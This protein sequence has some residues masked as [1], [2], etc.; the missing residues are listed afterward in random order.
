ML[1][2]VTEH[3]PDTFSLFH[4]SRSK[5]KRKFDNDQPGNVGI[6]GVLSRLTRPKAP[7]GSL[8]RPEEVLFF[9]T[10][11]PELTVRECFDVSYVCRISETLPPLCQIDANA[12][13]LVA[14]CRCFLPSSA[15]APVHHQEQLLAKE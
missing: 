2:G 12:S 6:W 11:R 1:E 3:P 7:F 14:C 10:V 8:S 9:G 13:M 4:G 15:T 5:R